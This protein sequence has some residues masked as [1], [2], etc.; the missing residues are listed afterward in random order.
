[1]PL[2]RKI[3]TGYI[4]AFVLLMIS[5]FFIFRSTWIL[6]REYDWVTNSYKAE[7]KIGEL[8]NSIVEVETGVRGYY[9]TGDRNFLKSFRKS[10]E[11]TAGLYNELQTLESKNPEQLARLDTIKRL[12]DLRLAL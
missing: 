6:Q 2:R 3:R 9:I 11:N 5:Y 12:I 10:R 4:I 1:M 7:N 8:K